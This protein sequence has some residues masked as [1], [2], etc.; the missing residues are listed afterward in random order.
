MTWDEYQNLLII[1]KRYARIEH[2]ADDLLQ[3]ALI[4]AVDNGRFD[5]SSIDN[6]KWMHGV[7][8]NLATQQA[9]S[10]V[11][12][13]QRDEMFVASGE[14]A[15]QDAQQESYAEPIVDSEAISQVL[16]LLTPAARK[17]AVLVMQGLDRK[18][19]CALLDLPDTAFRQRLRT[20]KKALEPVSDE[21]KKEAIAM[22]Y[23]SRRNHNP[24]QQN[25][26]LG[27]IRNALLRQLEREKTNGRQAFGT[28]DP[29]G[30]L[31]II[32]KA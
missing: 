4:I 29:T 25:L 23:V 2:E 15:E 21:L 8:R 22:A 19:I 24:D 28:H 3:D 11:R 6:Q 14:D 12:R 26:P 9:R 16:T 5:F 32:H 17:V 13:K 30:H 27:L 31:I 20:I 7:V 1:A 10:A 18:E